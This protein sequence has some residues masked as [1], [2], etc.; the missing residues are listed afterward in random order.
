MKFKITKLWQIKM[1]KFSNDSSTE[2]IVT[3][4]KVPT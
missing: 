3:D 4:F 1:K 2:N